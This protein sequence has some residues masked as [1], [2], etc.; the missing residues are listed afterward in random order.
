MRRLPPARNK[1]R[2]GETLV[3]PSQK[4]QKKRRLAAPFGR[5]TTLAGLKIELKKKKKG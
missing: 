3:R 5:K 1:E 4:R 2:N